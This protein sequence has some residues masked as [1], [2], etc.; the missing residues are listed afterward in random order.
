MFRA[1]LRIIVGI[2][3]VI[4]CAAALL[5]FARIFG[6]GQ[7]EAADGASKL[8]AQVGINCLFLA[9]SISCLRFAI[10]KKS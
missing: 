2:V 4:L 3:G 9:V 1:L 10:S 6:S 7:A 8:A 5:A